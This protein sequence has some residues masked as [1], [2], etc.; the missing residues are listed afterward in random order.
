MLLFLELLDENLHA[1]I[2][3]N[4][5]HYARS[6]F[7]GESMD[8]GGVVHLFSVFHALLNFI[9]NTASFVRLAA[10]ALNHAG[11]CA[12]VFMLGQ[13][14]EHVPGGKVLHALVLVVGH[15]VLVSGTGAGG[16]L[17]SFSRQ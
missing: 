8:E 6:M 3:L 15:L 7:R 2:G 14:V 5:E 11:L 10:F 17:R 12:A 4:Q 13:M 1:E 9:S 16:L